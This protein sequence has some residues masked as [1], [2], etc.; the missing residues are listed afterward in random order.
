MCCDLHGCYGFGFGHRR[1]EHSHRYLGDT[2][3]DYLRHG[4]EQRTAGCVSIQYLQLFTGCGSSA[5]CRVSDTFSDVYSTDTTVLRT[6]ITAVL[7]VNKAALSL[8]AANAS[9]AYGVAN[10]TFTGGVTGAVNGDT[11]TETFSTSAVVSSTVGNYSIVPA[12]TGTNSNNYT[13]TPVNGVLTVVP[14]GTTTSLALSNGNLTFSATVA[15][16]T[17]SGVPTGS[18][19]F[20]AGSKHCWGQAH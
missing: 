12:V 3:A 7:T 18:V 6:T 9:R 1:T 17:G 8:T 11:F 14:A 10:P 19:S 5:G 4:F 15:P 16:A 13:I 20:Y 2:N